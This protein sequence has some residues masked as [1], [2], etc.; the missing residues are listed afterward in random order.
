[1]F[2]E[3][4]S[5]KYGI[6]REFRLGLTI[7]VLGSCRIS[8]HDK[9]QQWYQNTDIYTSHSDIRKYSRNNINRF[10]IIMILL[11]L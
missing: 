11:S 7:S 4:S 3:T 5:S 9:L 8:V 10:V 6:I 1:M 2:I